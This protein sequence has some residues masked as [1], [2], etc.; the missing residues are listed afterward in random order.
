M[1]EELK[2]HIINTLDYLKDFPSV[3]KLTIQEIEDCYHRM[4]E[5]LGQFVELELND[6]EGQDGT[7]TSWWLYENVDKKIYQEVEDH[8]VTYDV[9]DSEDFVNYMIERNE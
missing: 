2:Q 1:K 8:Q 3:N 6:E 4:I 7:M 5:M 9:E